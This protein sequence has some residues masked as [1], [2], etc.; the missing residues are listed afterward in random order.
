LF[1]LGVPGQSPR[2]PDQ[3]KIRVAPLSGQ[4]VVTDREILT[5]DEMRRCDM[6]NE[7][8]A[9]FGLK[10]WAVIG[11][12]AESALWGLSIQRSSRRGPFE[13]RDTRILALLSQRLTETATLS[14]S[15]GRAVL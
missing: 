1:L 7:L 15:V 8:L 11:F 10:W 5:P 12:W 4:K 6:Y 3:I 13:P 14:K 2:T 9:P